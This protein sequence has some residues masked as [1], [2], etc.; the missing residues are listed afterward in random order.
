M[1]IKK[2]IKKALISTC[3]YFTA[4][5]ALYMLILQIVNI[6]SGAAA[7]EAPRV[8]LFLVGSLLFAIAGVILGI[9]QLRLAFRIIIHYLIC[10]LSFFICI[11]LPVQTQ[12]SGGI[13][14]CLVL[15][16]LVYAIAAAIVGAFRSRLRANREKSEVYNNQYK[17]KK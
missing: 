11:L 17:K 7:V 6:D 12:S 16:T 5:M 15:F 1:E 3:I 9:G 8:L 10:I 2:L 4:I 14:I 13:F